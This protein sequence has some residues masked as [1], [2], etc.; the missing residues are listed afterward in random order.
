MRAMAFTG[1]TMP[2]TV[3]IKQKNTTL[4]SVS[5]NILLPL[6]RTW[7]YSDNGDDTNKG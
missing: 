1:E 4:Y 7:R 2:K 5:R 6:P 3:L